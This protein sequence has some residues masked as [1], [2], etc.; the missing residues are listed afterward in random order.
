VDVLPIVE[1]KRDEHGTREVSSEER[2]NI[3]S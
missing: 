1:F 3:V 2:K